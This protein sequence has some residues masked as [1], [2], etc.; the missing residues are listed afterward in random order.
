MDNDI[1]KKNIYAEFALGGIRNRNKIRFKNFFIKKGQPDCFRSIF[2]FEK[3]LREYVR[4]KSSVTGY[5][6]MHIAD[7]LIYDLDNKEDLE[8]VR[9]EAIKLIDVFIKKYKV[10][11][12][13]IEIAFS[14][15]KGI[16]IRV[17]FKAFASNPEPKEDFYKLYK[18]IALEIADGIKFI[19]KSIYEIR[20]LFRIINSKHSESGLF[21]VNISYQELTTSIDEIKK[22]AEKP[23]NV[24]PQ[25]EIEVINELNELYNKYNSIQ[26]EDHKE[27]ND[28][29]RNEKEDEI[30]KVLEEGVE[31]GLRHNWLVKIT[32]IF[33]RKRFKP[34]TTLSFLKMWNNKNRPPLPF[35]ELE[36][37][38]ESLYKKK[39]DEIEIDASN[40]YDL[41]RA[42]E[43]YI[44]QNLDAN[45]GFLTGFSEIDRKIR[46]VKP[47]EVF[48]LIG[49]TG[50]GKSA[51]SLFLGLKHNKINEFP[52]L[53][54]SL[55]MSTE[56]MFE[57]VLQIEL[58][59]SGA[60]IEEF[61]QTED[62]EF[63]NQVNEIINQNK[64]FYIV[65]KSSCSIAEIKSLVKFYEENVY[66]KKTGLILIDY[67]SLLKG[68]GKSLY[69]EVSRIARDIKGL[70]KD[71]NVPIIILSQ[72][73]KNSNG[74]LGLE[75]ARDSGAVVE[76]SDFVLGIW[77][78]EVMGD[79][80]YIHFILGIL[81]NRKGG[82]TSI[83]IKMS[84]KNLRFTDNN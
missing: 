49:A 3:S 81:K 18:S 26:Y 56:L 30:E 1:Y 40:I 20:R 63:K 59:Y 7:Y 13:Y 74:E 53:Y 14:G 33:K 66:H 70:A 32:G 65:E 72:V 73:T 43:V 29:T 71:L 50:N 22:I 55:E 79:D 47:G 5:I 4:E 21:K 52:T 24:L 82:L 10:P 48:C 8:A 25:P 19:D 41:K 27:S 35:E 62:V 15:Y 68:R 28:S 39:N 31:E 77:K 2:L 45:G 11:L 9:K 60:K 76:A 75:A 69:E 46:G 36:Q 67:L 12:E 54:F 58:R 78:Q 17:P 44:N 51:I 80:E 37:V 64:N 38:V 61:Y 83:P 84:K 34:T 57:R 23:R 16:S 6:G 42:E